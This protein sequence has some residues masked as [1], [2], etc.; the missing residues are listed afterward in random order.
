MNIFELDKLIAA[1]EKSGDVELL[2]FYLKKR[3]ELVGEIYEKIGEILS[4][5]A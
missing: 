2:K 5:N 1:V 3:A 4:K